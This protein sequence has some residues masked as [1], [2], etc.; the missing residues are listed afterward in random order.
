MLVVPSRNQFVRPQKEDWPRADLLSHD[1][2]VPLFDVQDFGRGRRLKAG[3]AYDLVPR[4]QQQV[5]PDRPV[6]KDR[7]EDFN[8]ASFGAAQWCAVC[9]TKV[10]AFDQSLA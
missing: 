9:V 1:I 5:H 3:E 6:G 4:N 7:K 10:R 2:T 8:D